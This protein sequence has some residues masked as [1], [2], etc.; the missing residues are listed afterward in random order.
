MEAFSCRVLLPTKRE[1]TDLHDVADLTQKLCIDGE[2]TVKGIIGLRNETQ[3]KLSL[4][5]E[6]S[7][8]VWGRSVSA[9]ASVTARTKSGGCEDGS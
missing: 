5:H 9:R 6:Q 7:V 4:E 3:S 2:T 1:C 8:S